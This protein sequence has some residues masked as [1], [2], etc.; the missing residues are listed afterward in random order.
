MADDG[1][2]VTVP[3]R[4]RGALRLVAWA[5]TICSVLLGTA[6]LAAVLAVSDCSFAGGTC[7]DPDPSFE[8][9]AFWFGASAGALIAAPPLLLARRRPMVAAGST[10]VAA[11]LAGLVAAG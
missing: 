4:R 8:W 5:A 10:A 9:D 1:S 3:E 7:P 2:D 11:V 6:L